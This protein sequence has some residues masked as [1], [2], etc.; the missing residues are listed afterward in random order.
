M[1]AMHPPFARLARHIVGEPRT[2]ETEFLP[3]ALELVE[4][5]PSPIGRAMAFTIILFLV[6]ALAW[7]MIGRVDIIAT[8]TGSVLPTGMVK[9]VQAADGGIV[10]AIRV[11]DG[12]TVHRGD[13]LVRLDPTATAAD[14]VN[15]SQDLWRASLDA[16]RL[17]ALAHGGSGRF[18][19]PSGAPAEA[20]AD[21]RT[22]LEAE[23][24]AQAARLADLDEQIG[25]KR[26]EAG[27]VRAEIDQ[28][29]AVLPILEQKNAIYDK[30]H[31]KGYSTTVAYLDAQQTVQAGR[32]QRIILQQKLA[33]A[34][35]ERAALTQQRDTARS[36]FAAKT[37]ADLAIAE[38]HRDELSQQFVKARQRTRQTEIRAPID[39]V[40]EQLALHTI[41]GVVTPAQRLLTVVPETDH[42]MVEALLPNRDV[43]FVRRGQQVQVKIETFNFTKYGLLPGTVIE[44]ARDSTNRAAADQA[45]LPQDDPRTSSSGGGEA[46]SYVV[47]IALARSTMEIEGRREPLRPGMA[48]TAEIKTGR[49]TIIDYLLSPLARRSSESLHER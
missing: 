20:V 13:V 49:R 14:Q 5:P 30:L 6:F 32:H 46:Q 37:M 8:A 27:G 28:L 9:V 42:L 38:Q 44:V 16:A 29:D 43:G 26:A 40:V 7:A 2:T 45:A 22:T 11:Q 48:V 12:D 24:A 23:R 21:S 36:E 25:Q 47:R 17:R 10:S 15:A 1:N 19:A 31:S 35:A 4:T 3:A 33:Q 34:Q 39:G 18:V 41:G